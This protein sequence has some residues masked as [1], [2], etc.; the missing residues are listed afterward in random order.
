MVGVRL[1]LTLFLVLT[2][3]IDELRAEMPLAA[4]IV[5]AA[6]GAVI[7]QAGQS[8]T[9]ALRRQ[10]IVDLTT[11]LIVVPVAVLTGFVAADQGSMSSAEQSA[12]FQ[13]FGGMLLALATVITLGALLF[14]GDRVLLP[15]ILLPALLMPIAVNFVL[16]D[17][18]NQTVVAMIAVSYFV[19]T[20]AIVLGA[21]MDDPVRRYV[22]AVFYGATILGGL[23]LFDPGL[24]GVF[25]RDGL[26][27]ASTFVLM[28]IGMGVLILIP[29]PSIIE[30]L[31]SRPRP[32][33]RRVT[34][35]AR[36][37]D[38]R[39]SSGNTEN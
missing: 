9:E 5:V 33:R 3:V 4:L 12:M 22:P 28:L 21:L 24:S 25:E 10:T 14:P 37:R 29:N 16:H 8:N 34:N 38:Y 15:A 27:Q 30:D 7:F 2:V 1:G 36:R 26:V 17:Y 18:R 20:A 35:R 19:G 11:F 6:L 31:T 13:T 39:D 32:D 23:A